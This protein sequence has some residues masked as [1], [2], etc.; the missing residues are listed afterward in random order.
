[1]TLEEQ[2]EFWHQNDEYEKII[3]ELEKIPDTERSHKLTGLL[4]RAYEN[5][6]GGTEHPEVSSSRNR[7]FKK[8][9]RRK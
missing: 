3:E 8:R 5:A 2:L 9:G 4:A 6:A 1:M 7:A